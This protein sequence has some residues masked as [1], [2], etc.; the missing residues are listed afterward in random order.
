MRT[1]FAD[2]QNGVIYSQNPLFYEEW[3]DE[4]SKLL[5]ACDEEHQR[6]CQALSQLDLSSVRS[7]KEH[8]ESETPE[9]LTQ[10]IRSI[11]AFRGLFSPM[12]LVD[13]GFVPDFQSRYFTADFPYGLDILIQ[14]A[15][16]AGVSVPYMEEASAWYH[17]VSGNDSSFHLNEYGICSLEALYAVYSE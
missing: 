5:F 11:P 17:Q 4:S 6:L 1:L 8:Y 7:L 10:K 14:L 13:G 3:S 12:K 2:Y 16:L 9:A 15:T